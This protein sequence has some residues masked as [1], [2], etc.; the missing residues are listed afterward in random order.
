MRAA[1]LAILL[2][3]GA[4]NAQVFT[5]SDEPAE[6]PPA[7]YTGK[8]YV[9]SRGCVFIRAGFDG[10]VVW[11]PR[12]TR[13]RKNLCGFEPTVSTAPTNVVAPPE[14]QSTTVAAAPTPS[15]TETTV[16]PIP[17]TSFV[18]DEPVETPRQVL[19]QQRPTQTA[20]LSFVVPKGYKVAWDDGRLNPDR[21]PRNAADTER[22]NQI[23]TQTVPRRL[24]TSK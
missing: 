18:A 3:T 5:G 10:D 1:F 21:G 17:V 20:P 14:P 23:W 19:R 16:A 4:A 24:I 15:Q 7:N 13:D 6:F 8:Q 11:V 12:V 9:D 2:T 22:M